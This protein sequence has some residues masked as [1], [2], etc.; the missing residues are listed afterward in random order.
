M[1]GLILLDPGI[2]AL[3]KRPYEDD[4][5]MVEPADDSG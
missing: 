3:P 2:H 5:L 4:E 1:P